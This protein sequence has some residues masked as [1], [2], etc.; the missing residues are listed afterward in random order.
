MGR[1]KQVPGIGAWG[2]VYDDQ[3]TSAHCA[4]CERLEAQNRMLVSALRMAGHA[5]SVGL[6]EA[7][8]A[9]GEVVDLD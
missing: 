1:R 5:V 7:A 4:E 9:A 2:N 3:P 8:V 6:A